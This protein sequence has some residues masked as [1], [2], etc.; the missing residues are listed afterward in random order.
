MF[1]ENSNVL[2]TVW[3]LE[4]AGKPQSE[5]SDD[6]FK[7]SATLNAALG[8]FETVGQPQSG[9]YGAFKGFAIL[10]TATGSQAEEVLFTPAAGGC[11]M[12][13]KGNTNSRLR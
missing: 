12:Y 2:Q 13:G 11:A 3:P 9:P 1:C 10:N 7:G 8:P 5:P 4:A 6:V